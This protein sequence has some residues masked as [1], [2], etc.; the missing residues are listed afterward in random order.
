V[1]FSFFRA[2]STNEPAEYERTFNPVQRHY[3]YGEQSEAAHDMAFIFF[4]LWKLP[5]ETW[6]ETKSM[7]FRGKRSWE[8]GGLFMG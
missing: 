5:V 8:L 1:G 4:Q 7:A 3:Q 2:N 6:I